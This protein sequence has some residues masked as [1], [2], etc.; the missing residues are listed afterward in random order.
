MPQGSHPG[1]VTDTSAARYQSRS[2][3]RSRRTAK[4]TR[5]ATPWARA[6]PRTR[7][8]SV[9]NCSPGSPDAP[10]TNSNCASMPGPSSAIAWIRL[11]MPLRGINGPTCST[12]KRSAGSPRRCRAAAL[13]P[14]QKARMS[15]PQ[16]TVAMRPGGAPYRRIR[17]PLSCGH[18][19]INRSDRCASAHS[20]PMRAAA[21]GSA[22]PWSSRCI[23][24]RVWKVVTSGTPEARRSA[25]PTQPDSK[26][27][28]CNTSWRWP[29]DINRRAASAKA[30]MCSSRSCRGTTRGGPASICSTRTPRQGCTT[31]GGAVASRRVSRS[32]W[33]PAAASACATWAT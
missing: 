8:I 27:L 24:P 29:A 3:S 23:S 12:R 15:T 25:S 13:S 28:A 5:C 9:A 33:W 18:P 22:S 19:A 4:C 21:N 2:G 17:S 16:G 11:S 7:A 20:M 10:P 31:A 1:V 6:K 26:E 30:G 14:G 32:T